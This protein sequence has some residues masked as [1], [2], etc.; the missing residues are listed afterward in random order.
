MKHS[1]LKTVQVVPYSGAEAPVVDR[2]GYLSAILG[3]N[4]GKITGA[5][6]SAKLSV[7]LLHSD[8]EE[9]SFVAVEDPMLYIGDPLPGS[10]QEETLYNID[11]DLLA[12]KRYIKVSASVA[13]EGGTDAAASAACALALGDKT[14]NPV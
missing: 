9:G 14:S 2:L 8:T 11:I 12:C 10:V 4:I 5:P 13:L 6:I 7:S 3:V 1:M